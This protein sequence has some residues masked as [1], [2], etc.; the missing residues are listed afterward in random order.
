MFLILDPQRLQIR[1]ADLK[2]PDVKA[3][4]IDHAYAPSGFL[5]KNLGSVHH[6]MMFQGPQHSASIPHTKGLRAASVHAGHA[7]DGGKQC[8]GQLFRC[9]ITQAGV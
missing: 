4:P 2:D 1:R 5:W 3:A 6:N 7:A 8:V 9:I